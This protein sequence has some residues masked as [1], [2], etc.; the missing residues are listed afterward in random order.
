MNDDHQKL[1]FMMPLL[2][3]Y[4]DLVGDIVWIYH[5]I[6]ICIYIYISLL[7]TNFGCMV[8]HGI[9][10]YC[11]AY[12]VATVSQLEF[13]IT[14][15][16]MKE[17]MT[18]VGQGLSVFSRHTVR[19]SMMSWLACRWGFQRSP[20]KSEFNSQW[21][22]PIWRFP[23]MGIPKMDGEGKIH[24]WMMTGGSPTLGDPS[25]NPLAT[26]NYILY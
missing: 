23:K 25:N 9:A 4:L 15:F 24:K 5:R 2:Q 20:Q 16:Y 11:M 13:M 22:W 21:H 26:I 18:K 6:C 3:E 1:R 7:L 8:L 19:R 17:Q 12:S 10:W 14:A